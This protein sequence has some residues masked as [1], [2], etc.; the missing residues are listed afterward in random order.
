MRQYEL[1]VGDV[2]KI[3]GVISL[4]TDGYYMDPTYG[5]ISNFWHWRPILEDGSLGRTKCGYNNHMEHT[6]GAKL[7]HRVF[8]K[9]SR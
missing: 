9:V 7:P 1:C 6:F 2:R 3:D 5:R 4:I 8:I